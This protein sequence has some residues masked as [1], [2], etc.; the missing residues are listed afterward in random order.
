MQIN[1]A[2]GEWLI[3]KV[4][5]QYFVIHISLNTHHKIFIKKNKCLSFW[6]IEPF[7]SFSFQLSW[8]WLGGGGLGGFVYN[9]RVLNFLFIFFIFKDICFNLN[10]CLYMY[11]FKKLNKIRDY[12]DNTLDKV[13]IWFVK[14]S[15]EIN[16]LKTLPFTKFDI[17]WKY[18]IYVNF[19]NWLLIELTFWTNMAASIDHGR[20]V[21]KNAKKSLVCSC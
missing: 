18:L 20:E 16:S 3:K 17:P 7:F 10:M 11:F 13:K 2:I 1:V 15:I 4:F 21:N 12:L 6:I 9:V 8:K 14:I 19:T 5:L